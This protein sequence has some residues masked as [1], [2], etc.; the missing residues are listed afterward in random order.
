ML[1]EAAVG[2][3][4]ALQAKNV[5]EG[6]SMPVLRENMA[7]AANPRWLDI[8]SYVLSRVSGKQNVT[9]NGYSDSMRKRCVTVTFGSGSG[10]IP[11]SG[12]SK[13]SA[14]PSRCKK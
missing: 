11:L 5:P 13:T 9:R 7:F 4:S 12:S 3:V 6:V 10:A 2:H 1:A 14:K 8:C